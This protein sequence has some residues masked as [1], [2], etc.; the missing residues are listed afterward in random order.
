MESQN[1][2]YRQRTKQFAIGII[3]FVDALPKS[4]AS[5]VLGKQLLRSATSV[6]ANY[7]AICLARSDAEKCSK[8]C[9]V[10]EEADES[11]FWLELIHE[12]GMNQFETLQPLLREAGELTRIFTAYRMKLREVSSKS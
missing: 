12:S 9:I 10:V 1:D 8:L 3:T 7:R 4:I 5:F 2:V 6:A 11:L